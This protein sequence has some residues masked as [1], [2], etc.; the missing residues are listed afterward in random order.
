MPSTG[1]ITDVE[2][3]FAKIEE[4]LSPEQT[5]FVRRAYELA[6]DAHKTQVRKS[7]EPY[8]IHPI[9]VVGILVGLQMDETTLA[10]AFLHDVVED[11]DYTLDDLKERFGAVVAN[12]VD[13]VTK[14]GKIEYISKEDRQI[15][16]YRKM[17]LAMA[18]DIRVVLIKLADRLH[19]MR[20]MKY[21]PVHKQQSI[22][23]ETLEIYTPLAHRLGIYTIKWELEDLAFR[24]MEPE[25]YY[26]LMEQVKIKRR[27]REA[28]INDAMET[29]KKALE[30][31]GIRC[32]IQGRPKNFYSIHKKMLRDHKQLS[33]IYDLLAIRVLVDTVTD[34]YGTLGIVHSMWKPIPGR[35]KDYVAVP[36]S[37][38]YQ[39]LH[40]TVLSSGGQPLEI[41]I[42]T[43][44]MHRISE[45]GIAAHWRYKESGGS[46]PAAGGDKGFDAK[47]SWLRQLLEWHNDMNDSRDFVNTVKMDIFADEVFVFTPRGDVIDLPV[48]SVPI[49]FAYRIH[50][51]V[52]N[53]CVGAKVNGRIVPLD[54]Q[55]KNGDIV[56]VITSKQSSG[57]SRDWINIV[58]SSDTRNKIK[59]W[60]KKERRE[61]N[62]VKGREMLEREVKRLGYDIKVMTTPEKL[63]AVG[64]KLRIDTDENLLATLGYGGVTLNTVM[65]KLVE[66]Y[67]KEQ[68]LE[69]TKDLAQVLAELKPRKSKAK[70]SHGILVKGEEGIM[71]K[72]ARCCNPIPGDPVIGYITRGSGISVHRAD[73]PNVLSN[74]PDEQRRLIEVSWDVGIDDVY[75]VNIMI[76]SQDRPGMM[77]DIMNI[78]SEAKLN[79]FSLSCHTDKNK[80]A[81]THMGLD[82]TSLEQLEY[83]M[84]RIR[85]MKGVYNVERVVSTANAGGGKR[86]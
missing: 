9:G 65:S 29:L 28:M 66:L 1:T 22:S 58:G 14:L 42:R 56:E 48:G 79:I 80:T 81:T 20:T 2:E 50:T 70:S 19:N 45:Y 63:R 86:K 17:F 13:G 11:T 73:C 43:F 64:N 12:L 49:D 67:K 82:I 37:N 41:Q 3:L 62:I 15:E 34:C 53:R 51:D 6:A 10:A 40:T 16:N 59:N 75:K 38:M 52:G 8:I 23:R 71:V 55:L 57:P 69:T 68:K 54:Y 84:N 32:E 26:D 36:K 74:N 77:S 31:A 85:R 21:M 33:E 47:L 72:L 4:Y 44:E 78:T 7:G 39:S 5:A 61:E 24:Y 35:F 60:F 76:T 27:E 83:V 25:I 30:K 18:R 46:K